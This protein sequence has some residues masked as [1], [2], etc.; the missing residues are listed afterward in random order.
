MKRDFGRE[1]RDRL[2]CEEV[3]EHFGFEPNRSMNILCPFHQEKTPSLHIY[4]D[5]WHCFGCGASG[6]CIDFVMR[7]YNIPFVQAVALMD[8]SFHLGLLDESNPPT[9][10][11]KSVIDELIDAY[12]EKEELL[13]AWQAVIDTADPA[14]NIWAGAVLYAGRLRCE[15]KEQMDVLFDK[16]IRR[17]E[18]AWFK[19]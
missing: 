5:G 7:L 11:R 13:Q 14:G 1:I 4:P 15:L 10:K 16:G 8:S 3:I 18:K 17:G 9:V 12:E 6:D 2:T 19:V